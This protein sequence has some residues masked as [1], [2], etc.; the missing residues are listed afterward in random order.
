MN[1]MFRIVAIVALILVVGC[2]AAILLLRPAFSH[3]SASQPSVVTGSGK[4]QSEQRVVEADFDSIALRAPGELTIAPGTSPSMV[5]EAEDNILE[6]IRTRAENGVLVIE[7]AQEPNPEL[8]LHHP[9]RY[10][11]T[12]PHIR[13]VEIDGAGN[14]HGADIQAE[15]LYVTINGSGSISLA[16][17]VHTEVIEIN[18]GGIYQAADME[19]QDVQIR[20]NG[21]AEVTVW[22]IQR[23]NV[24]CAGTCAIKYY[25]N[26]VVEKD[27]QGIGVVSG[28]G[29]R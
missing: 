5:I 4:T 8:R 1:S 13:S 15:E 27:L 26:P 10:T 24:E 12:A 14:I 18:G 11:I 23:L 17:K 20:A 28:L 9:I 22:A 29:N 2:A 16:G 7:L 21:G 19:A 6:L 25:G 3:L